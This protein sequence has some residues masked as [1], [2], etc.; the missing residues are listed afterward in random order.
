MDLAISEPPDLADAIEQLH[1]ATAYFTCADIVSRMLDMLNWPS[2][3][4]RLVD[5]SCGDGAFLCAALERLLDA[6]PRINDDAI[7]HLLQGWEIHFDAAAEARA[8]LTQILVAHGRVRPHAKQIALRMVNHGDFLLQ[9]PRQATWDCVAG[10]PPYLR[11]ARLPE[12]LRARYES[13]LPDYSRGD[14]LHSFL[15]RC[16]LTLRPGGE[17]ALVSSDRWLFTQSAARL[18]G[19]IGRRLGIHYV[20]RIDGPSPFYRPKSRRAG[21]PP[22]IHPVIVML[23]EA[24]QCAMALTRLPIY[25]EARDEPPG[26]CPLASVA[27]VRLAPWLGKHGLFVIDLETAAAAGIPS[28][29]LVPAVDT[30]NIKGGLLRAPT[31]YAIQ[32]FRG[33]QPPAH[34]LRHLDANMHLLARTKRR[35]SQRWVPPETFERMDLTQPSL[36]IPRI[37]ASLRPVRLPPGLLPIDHGISIVTAGRAT[38]D[39]LEAY[40]TRPE[41]EAWVR[42]RAPRLENGYFSLTTTLLRALPVRP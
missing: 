21:Q 34:I 37:A 17:V 16:A 31:K 36:L 22:R 6:E 15:E 1:D 29:M 30:D 33:I 26:L 5:N 20:A 25:P 40:L 8:R 7:V 24:E 42:A 23:R 35:R 3:S 4:R 2:G 14:L 19:V 12:V 32:T 11:Y 18:R 28:S 27:N 41:A 9:G 39:E 13:A 10:N 38:L